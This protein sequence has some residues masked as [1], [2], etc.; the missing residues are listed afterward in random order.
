MFSHPATGP[1]GSRQIQTNA[2]LYP[3][4]SGFTNTGYH[5][6]LKMLPAYLML[7]APFGVPFTLDQASPFVRQALVALVSLIFCSARTIPS[8]GCC[9]GIR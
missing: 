6:Q 1:H 2:P 9:A 4:E 8:K 7:G 5:S 3:R